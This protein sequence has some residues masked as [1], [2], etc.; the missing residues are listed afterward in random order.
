MSD[1]QIGH[2]ESRPYR[3]DNSAIGPDESRPYDDVASFPTQKSK[4][5][6]LKSPQRVIAV[7]L[8]VALAAGAAYFYLFT[9]SGDSSGDVIVATVNGAM[10]RQSEVDVQVSL[11][12]A[13]NTSIGLDPGAVNA[14]DVLSNMVFQQLA[15]QDARKHNFPSASD[16]EVSD[17]LI[18]LA[19][20]SNITPTRF[21]INLTSYGV[22]QSVFSDALR[23]RLTIENYKNQKIAAT[24]LAP[25][26]RDLLFNNWV[27]GLYDAKVAQ[28][29]YPNK[30]R[31]DTGPAPRIG[32]MAPDIA[33]IDLN[34]GRSVTLGQLRGHP[35]VINFWATWCGPCRDEMPTIVSAYN[36]Y[37]DS[38]GLVVLAVDTEDASVKDKAVAF[39]SQ[40]KMSF[41]VVQDDSAHSIF[42]AY[43]IQATPSTFFVDGNGTIKTMHLGSMVPADLQTSLNMILQ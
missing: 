26:Q 10:I 43:D 1:L 33:G 40:F 4:V 11:N 27:V 36:T 20:T 32:R 13:I 14:D 24:T 35:V 18:S 25:D 21:T 8:F 29:T 19:A 28:I 34:T 17:Y 30:L 22:A 9:S 41:P 31:D 2:D 37:H 38:K 16:A 23:T 6:N 3:R 15:L 39:V 5:K 42:L 7:I 12:R